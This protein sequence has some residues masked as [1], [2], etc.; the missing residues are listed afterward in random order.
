MYLTF[1]NSHLIETCIFLKS[2]D[3]INQEI[4]SL[5]TGNNNVESLDRINQEIGDLETGNNN[6]ESLDR[7]NQEIGDLETEN[8]AV[9]NRNDQL[10]EE[11]QNLEK[12]IINY[13]L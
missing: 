6:V 9:N 1:Y 4:G 13:L 8:N 12:V 2:L 10:R 11:N 5:E 3:R 7:I